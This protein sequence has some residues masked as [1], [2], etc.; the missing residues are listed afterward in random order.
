LLI[1]IFPKKDEWNQEAIEH[2]KKMLRSMRGP[3]LT[4]IVTLNHFTL[5]LWVLTPPNRIT[6]NILQQILPSPLKDAPIG[7]PPST[8]PYWNSLRGWENY[9]TVEEFVK[10]VIIIKYE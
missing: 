3:G 5:P 6:K 2:Y 7:E 10:F 4:P 9:A 1:F 8:D